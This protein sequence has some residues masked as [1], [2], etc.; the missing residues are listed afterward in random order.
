MRATKKARSKISRS[1][2]SGRLLRAN[3][4]LTQKRH[5]PPGTLVHVGERASGPVRVSLMEYDGFR[6]R[7][8]SDLTRDELLKLPET[9]GNLWIHVE[10]LHDLAIVEALGKRFQLHP[11]VLEDLVNAAQRPK[12]EDT[13]EYLFF[14]VRM[15]R[16]SEETAEVGSE[17]MGLILGPNFLLTFRESTGSELDDVRER[18]RKAKGRIRSAGV[19][20]L[21]YC[22][23]DTVVD[24]FFVTLEKL[25]EKLEL[26]EEELVIKP[27]TETLESIHRLKT[28][29]IFL[30]RTVW[31][32]REVINRLL[33]SGGGLVKDA[34]VLY[35]RDVYDHTIHAIDTMETYREILS[36]MLDIYL[37]SMSNRLNRIMKVLTL[38]ATI[39][40]PLTFMT[41]WYG[42][43]FKTMPELEWQWGYASFTCLVVLVVAMMLISFRRQDWL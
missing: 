30:R 39:F 6:V 4:S 34:T 7:E 15:L 35:W 33:M 24:D 8:A 38:I 19:D 18:V 32:M 27:T 10:G 25:A 5:L 31:P 14:V 1:K 3:K 11:L 13:G 28:D 43:N 2:S 9:T 21:A 12:V 41:G 20:Y 36:G 42:M 37:S 23:V 29:M 22:L 26:L 40:I 17:Q 16:Y